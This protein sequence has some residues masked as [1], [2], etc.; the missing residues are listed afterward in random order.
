MP[1]RT[2]FFLIVCMMPSLSLAAVQSGTAAPEPSAVT[3]EA[4][5]CARKHPITEAEAKDIAQKRFL[6]E[7]D[8]NYPSIHVDGIFAE[9]A[10]T[11][12]IR[13][14]MYSQK[15]QKEMPCICAV[16]K[17]SGKCGIIMPPPGPELTKEILEKSFSW[18]N[19]LIA[20]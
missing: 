13:G 18:G 1:L 10:E 12:F 9:T 17:I 5:Q 15:A 6:R 4:K 19:W 11:F 20:F 3:C 16:H 2:A 7:V 14:Y 8:E